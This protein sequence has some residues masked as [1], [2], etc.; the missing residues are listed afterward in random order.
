MGK[1]ETIIEQ[2]IRELE[3]KGFKVNKDKRLTAPNRNVSIDSQ[4]AKAMMLNSGYHI[5]D[6][7][8]DKNQYQRIYY[9]LGHDA[10][11]TH[12]DALAIIDFHL[13]QSL[14]LQ[15]LIYEYSKEKA[16]TLSK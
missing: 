11:L 7:T 1:V 5:N 12:E 16:K 8:D 3:N 6:I 10:K 4:Y 13:Q 15:E 14:V 9:A 2:T